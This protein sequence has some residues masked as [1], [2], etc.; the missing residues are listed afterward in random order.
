MS[1]ARSRASGGPACDSL[2]PWRRARA[3]SC[4]ARRARACSCCARQ[5]RASS[6]PR[7]RGGFSSW[8]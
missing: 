3:S 2:R 4:C 5:S 8:P 6:P 1:R 7:R